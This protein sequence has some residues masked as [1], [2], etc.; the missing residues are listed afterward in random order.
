MARRRYGNRTA[1]WNNAVVGANGKS[2]ELEV[3]YAENLAIYITVSQATTVT[4][5]AG[6][7]VDDQP[8]QGSDSGEAWG[9]LV[10][11]GVVQERVFSAAGTAVILIADF[12]PGWV[13]LSNLTAATTIT[14][15]Y[16]AS[17]E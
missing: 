4:V 6:F 9:T 14:A 12:V 8:D 10:S 1:F 15:G 7:A 16:E 5:E 11:E 17:Q 2:A 3:G 13:R